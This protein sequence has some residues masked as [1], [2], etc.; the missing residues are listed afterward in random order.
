LRGE[1]QN[2]NNIPVIELS[3]TQVYKMARNICLMKMLDIAEE[4][5]ELIRKWT[6][7]GFCLVCI[8]PY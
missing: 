4:K 1:L 6:I 5:V 3:S 7:D 8:I 2:L